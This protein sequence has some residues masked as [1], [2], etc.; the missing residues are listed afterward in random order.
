MSFQGNMRQHALTHKN[1]DGGGPGSP[2]ASS[3]NTNS[4]NEQ[5]M[6]TEDTCDNTEQEQSDDEDGCSKNDVES[7]SANDDNKRTREQHSSPSPSR[8]RQANL[9]MDDEKSRMMKSTIPNDHHRQ[10]G[11]NED[12]SISRS[13]SNSSKCEPSQCSFPYI[14]AFEECLKCFCCTL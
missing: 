4:D 8:D 2:N 3:S 12:N 6:Q 1:S 13:Q 11:D 10:G 14:I 5:N 7:L 9:N